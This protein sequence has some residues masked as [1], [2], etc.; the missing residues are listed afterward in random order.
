MRLQKP[1]LRHSGLGQT[2]RQIA[3]LT[4][5][6]YPSF[7]DGCCILSRNNA[8][9][10]AMALRLLSHGRSVNVGSSDIGPRVVIGPGEMNRRIVRRGECKQLIGLNYQASIAVICILINEV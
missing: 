10:F 1:S 9:L 8:P 5:P 7:P 4:N 3:R 2:G 6:H